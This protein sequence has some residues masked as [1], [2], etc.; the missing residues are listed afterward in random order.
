MA[1][2][3]NLPRPWYSEQGDEDLNQACC[4]KDWAFSGSEGAA[5]T[6]AAPLAGKMFV[7]DIW[8]CCPNPALGHLIATVL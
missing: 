3:N 6:Q 1:S 4:S 8:S 2:S 7:L 5:F